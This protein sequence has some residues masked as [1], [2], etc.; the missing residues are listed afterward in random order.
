MPTYNRL[1]K[2][3]LCNYRVAEGH[4]LKTEVSKL[5]LKERR[6]KKY[7]CLETS[8]KDLKVELKVSLCL[9]TLMAV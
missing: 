4:V 6:P 9:K 2:I 3:H 1:S 8:T 5:L 7:S